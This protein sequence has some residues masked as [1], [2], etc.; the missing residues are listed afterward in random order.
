MAFPHIVRLRMLSGVL[1]G[2]AGTA[3]AAPPADAGRY[4]L[5]PKPGPSPKMNGPA[6]Y[7]ARPGRPFLYR[8]PVTG[9]RPMRFGAQGLPAPEP[10]RGRLANTP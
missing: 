5:T 8:I 2:L 1:L 3:A 4:I 6:V 10:R 9:D 7:G